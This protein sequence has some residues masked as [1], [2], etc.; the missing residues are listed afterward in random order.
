MH[1]DCE[2]V[3]VDKTHLELVLAQIMSVFQPICILFSYEKNPSNSL[4][5]PVYASKVG[6]LCEMD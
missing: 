3:N 1:Y 2:A 4:K 5:C 6:M